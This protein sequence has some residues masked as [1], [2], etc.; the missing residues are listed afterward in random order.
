MLMLDSASVSPGAAD[1][2][3]AS[4]GTV[5]ELSNAYRAAVHTPLRTREDFANTDPPHPFTAA[6]LLLEAIVGYD[7]F[8]PLRRRLL[9]RRNQQHDARNNGEQSQDEDDA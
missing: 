5:A 8:D 2:P 6:G 3:A 7:P 4:A 1:A 9:V